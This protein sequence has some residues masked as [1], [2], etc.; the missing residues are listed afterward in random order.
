MRKI[1]AFVTDGISPAAQPIV[2]S[3]YKRKIEVHCGESFCLNSSF[4]SRYVH[5]RVVYPSPEKDPHGFIKFILNYLKL[6]NIDILIPVRDAAFEAITKNKGLFSDLTNVLVPEYSDW[7]RGAEKIETMKLAKKLDIPIPVTHVNTQ[8]GFEFLETKLNLPF[9]V[10]LNRSSGARGNFL[11]ASE[12]EFYERVGVCENAGFSYFFQEW[13]PPGGKSYNASYLFNEGGS[14]VASFL[15]E[16]IRQYPIKGGS[17]SFARGVIDRD[18]LATGE[19]LLR[20]LHWQG[21]AEIEFLED[22]RDDQCKLLEIN[23]RFWNPLL[24]AIKSGVDFPWL[25]VQLLEGEKQIEIDN[26]STDITFSYLPYEL[27]NVIKTGN[28][29][30]FSEFLA[31]KKKH[32]DGLLSWRDPLLA[33]GFCVQTAYLFIKQRKRFFQRAW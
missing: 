7:T 26:Y 16:K 1:K 8:C 22:P 4:F 2:E 25:M 9:V 23:P 12:A 28:I 17:T 29:K 5:K 32:Y 20:G 6:N 15:M 33:L 3:L 13:I 21:V 19:R 14:A 11:V 10:K 31:F 27:M 24:L 30:I 18:L